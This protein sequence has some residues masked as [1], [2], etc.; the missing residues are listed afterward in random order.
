MQNTSP[1]LT[2]FI[3]PARIDQIQKMNAMIILMFMSVME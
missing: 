2:G 3:K 1:F